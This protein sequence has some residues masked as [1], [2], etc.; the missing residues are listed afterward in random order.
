MIILYVVKLCV[1]KKQHPV[2]IYAYFEYYY[3]VLT[4]LMHLIKGQ[5]ALL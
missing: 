4:F 3:W 5:Y 1:H 2:Y